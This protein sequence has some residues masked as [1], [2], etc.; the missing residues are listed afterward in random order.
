MLESLLASI[1]L[2]ALV[3]Y[4]FAGLTLAGAG[5]VAWSRNIIYAA[6]SLLAALAGVAGIFA[7]LSADFLAMVQVMVYVGGIL[8]LI[9]FAVMLTHRVAD[10]RQSNPS[11]NIGLGFAATA[12]IL[13]LLLGASATH[14]FATADPGPYAPTAARIGDAFLSRYLLPF[15]I[16]GVLLLAALVAAVTIARKEIKDLPPRGHPEGPHP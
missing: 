6:F 3:F 7:Y 4:G 10:G 13:A 15:E 8:V 14:P 12:I 16:A 9:L 2:P 1:S 11:R 5:G